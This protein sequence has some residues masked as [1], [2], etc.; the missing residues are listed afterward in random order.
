MPRWEPRKTKVVG[1]VQYNKCK[2]CSKWFEAT[3]EY[4]NYM[5]GKRPILSLICKLCQSKWRKIYYKNNKESAKQYGKLYIK[6]NITKIKNLKNNYAKTY[7]LFATFAHQL[8]IEES[9]KE[10][11]N[12]YLL[13]KC[14]YC[15]RY[16]Y[17]TNRMVM[18][19]IDSLLRRADGESRLYCSDGCKDACPIFNQHRWPKGFK[20]A[21]S[22][23]VDPIIRQMCLER[24]NY[25]CQKCEKTIDEIEIHSHHIEGAVQMP[26]LA[27]DVD[28]TITLCKPCHQWVHRQKGC[29]YYDMRCKK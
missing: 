5:A 1:G 26:L 6:N 17:P 8:T 11:E 21:T 15:G 28:N 22:R 19:R 27:N 10:E 20:P 18:H 3:N 7:A 2:K 25:T 13:T 23:E 9:P 12:G 24:D 29:T 4:F 16:F 14:A